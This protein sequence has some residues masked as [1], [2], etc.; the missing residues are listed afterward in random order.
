M[1]V[2]PRGSESPELLETLGR[3]EKKM[4]PATQNR[5]GVVGAGDGMN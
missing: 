3:I 2:S 5:L 4:G 1:A